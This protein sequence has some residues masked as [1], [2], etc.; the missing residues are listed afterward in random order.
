MSTKDEWEE[1]VDPATQKTFYVNHRT[2]ETRWH[3]PNAAM[4]LP[5]GWEEAR[6]AEGRIYYIDHA[7]RSTS[8]TDPRRRTN[9]GGGDVGMSPRP[10]PTASSSASGPSRRDHHRHRSTGSAAYNEDPSPPIGTSVSSSSSSPHATSERRHS[11]PRLPALL[12][13]NLPSFTTLR[14]G[15]ENGAGTLGLVGNSGLAMPPANLAEFQTYDLSSMKALKEDE[16][17]PFYVPDSM[18]SGCFLCQV[19]FQLVVRGRHHC[20]C[21]GEIVCDKCSQGKLA[22]PREHESFK[23]GAGGELGHRVCDH[24]HAHVATHGNFRCMVRYVTTLRAGKEASTAAQRYVA[25][26]LLV[27]ALEPSTHWKGD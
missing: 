17:D 8:W 1:V 22:L 13:Q 10:P 15:I 21:C 5:A 26:R 19:K 20:R 18:R 23:K 25:L 12:N 14:G 4:P 2:Q 3:K 6:D 7:T 27:E 16:V 11:L 24:C 9:S